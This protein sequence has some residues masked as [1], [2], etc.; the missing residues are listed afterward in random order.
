MVV[1]SN[2]KSPM[3]QQL[4]IEKDG[5]TMPAFQLEEST[6]QSLYN[7]VRNPESEINIV[8]YQKVIIDKK[9][10][11]VNEY[12]TILHTLDSA[13]YTFHVQ[14]DSLAKEKIL[15]VTKKK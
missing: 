11:S 9:D 1:F 14:M 8:D 7:S 2:C 12:L 10:Y 15:I 3:N 4:A 13:T 6:E 5:Y